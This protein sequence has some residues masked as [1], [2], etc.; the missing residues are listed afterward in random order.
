MSR[1]NGGPAEENASYQRHGA[2]QMKYPGR[3][4]KMGETDPHIVQALKTALNQALTLHGSEA[5]ELD[6]SNPNFG[7]RMKQAVK[8]FQ[9]RAIWT[10]RASP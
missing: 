3:V 1:S 4:I 2:S 5:I 10:A 9:A 8:L 7:P 6:A